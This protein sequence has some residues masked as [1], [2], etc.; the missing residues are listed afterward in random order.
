MPFQGAAHNLFQPTLPR[1][2]RRVLGVVTGAVNRFQPT[3]PRGERP[4]IFPTM[5]LIT[6]FNPR[7]HEGSDLLLPDTLLF[8]HQISTHAPTRGAT[9]VNPVSIKYLFIST[10]AP[11]RGATY[12]A[13]S[14]LYHPEFQPT[15]PRGERRPESL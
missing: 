11:T 10:H 3:L 12:C 7:S 13:C 5:P 8:P 15:L 6:D 14:G 9:F 4:R 2:E 1:G